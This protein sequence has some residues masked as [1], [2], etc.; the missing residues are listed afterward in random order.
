MLLGAIADDFTGASDLANTLAKGGMSTV[1]FSGFGG[2]APDCEAG[3]VALKTRS[4]PV[5][6]AVAQSLA[7]ARWLLD[8]GCEQLVFKYCSTFDSTPQGNIG[9]VA[10]ALLDLL[11]AEVA[12]VCPAFPGAGRRLFMGHLFVGDRLLSETG[13]RHHPLTPMTDPD[14]RRWLALQTAGDV[15]SILLDTVRAGPEAV[16]AAFAA[17]AAAGRRLVV[18]D[19]IADEDLMTIGAAVADHRLVTGGSGIAQGLPRNF[20]ARLGG[21]ADAAAVPA[22]TGP[23]VVLCGS[24]STA[25]QRQVALYAASHPALAVDPAALMEGEIS[26][27][28]VADWIARQGRRTP[29]VYSTAAPEAV[30][31]AQ[32]RFGRAAVAARFEDFFA[33]LARRLAD[34][35]TRRIVVGGGETSGAIVEA[36]ELSSM[37]VGREIDPGV[38]VLVGERD[39]PLGLALKSGN[40][41]AEDFFEKALRQVG[42]P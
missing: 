33:A 19:A 38:P 11:G 17:E 29:I 39:G 7:A 26:V 18:A 12:V 16:R 3:V 10:E 23:G 22:V 25:S 42:A 27:D 35:G 6:D 37:H 28:G 41:G 24:C 34:T 30:A 8:Q 5:G 13:M 36:L 21:P 1:Q 15:G 4:A 2:T 9:P 31:D 40:F 32:A 14:I 20:R